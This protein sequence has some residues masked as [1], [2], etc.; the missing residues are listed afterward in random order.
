MN[1]H[2]RP[3]MPAHTCQQPSKVRLRGGS[4]D[5]MLNYAQSPARQLFRDATVHMLTKSLCTS[6]SSA[7]KMPSL[8]PRQQCPSIEGN[9]KSWI[10]KKAEK[11]LTE[12]D[13]TE[14]RFQHLAR[15]KKANTHTVIGV[16]FSANSHLISFI[17]FSF[18]RIYCCFTR[19]SWTGTGSQ[20]LTGIQLEVPTSSDRF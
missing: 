2:S 9:K 6:V 8:P 4:R 1:S 3:P 16:T 18:R 10:L 5:P 14:V 19:Y 7:G 11:F 12:G 20:T 17:S 15:C 13:L